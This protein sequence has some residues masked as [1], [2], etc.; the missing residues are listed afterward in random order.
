ME[1]LWLEAYLIVIRNS[2]PYISEK[3]VNKAKTNLVLLHVSDDKETSAWRAY[4][5]PV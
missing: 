4:S 3:F 2:S 1:K 5:D